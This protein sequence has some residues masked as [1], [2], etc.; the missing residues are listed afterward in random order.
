MTSFLKFA[1]EFLTLSYRI[2]IF[3]CS[4]R[5]YFN[6]LSFRLVRIFESSF[7]ID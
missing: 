4:I 5:F 6:R 7:V 3:I 2:K 1:E